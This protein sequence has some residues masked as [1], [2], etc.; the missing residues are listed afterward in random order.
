M[1][2]IGARIFRNNVALAWTGNKVVHIKQKT[3]IMLDNGDVIIR[4]ARPIHAG[5]CEGSSDYIGFFPTII[6]DDM[7][8]KKVAIFTACE[9]KTKIGRVSEKQKIFIDVV[10]SAGGIAFVA[11]SD[12]EAVNLC[13]L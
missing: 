10:K 9:V 7:V 8:G 11:R 3:T 4:G 12:D 6:T 5:L 2:N 1:S 13:K